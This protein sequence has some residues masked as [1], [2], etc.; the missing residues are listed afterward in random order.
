MGQ[1]VLDLERSLAEA[2]ASVEALRAMRTT[3][4]AAT[5]DRQHALKVAQQQIE[6]M[7]GTL[8]FLLALS[9]REVEALEMSRR[10]GSDLLS[11]PRVLRARRVSRMDLIASVVGSFPVLYL[12]KDPSGNGDAIVGLKALGDGRAV[13]LVVVTRYNDVFAEV[14]P[15][16]DITERLSGYGRW[17]PEDGWQNGFLRL[18]G[19]DVFERAR[20]LPSLVD[21]RDGFIVWDEESLRK[22]VPEGD[23]RSRLTR[24][25]DL[26]LRTMDPE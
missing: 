1:T 12:G 11:H 9:G 6:T 13:S 2:Y 7:E 19:G 18:E 3:S 14:G 8:P 24:E 4:F 23:W 22:L 10:L 16:A 21:T 15:E 17:F 20:V 5:R 26:D 25:D